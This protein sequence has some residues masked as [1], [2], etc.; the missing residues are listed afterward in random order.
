MYRVLLP[1]DTDET[2]ARAQ[3]EAVLEL[4][5]AAD[6]VVVDVV[7]VYED[8]TARDAE[9]AAG[10]F[11]DAFESEMAKRSVED[12][13]PPSIETIAD[14]LEDAGIEYTL[15]ETGGKPAEKILEAAEELD[16][17]VMILGVAERTPVGKVLFGSVAQAVILSSE[18]PVMTVS[19]ERV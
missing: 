1:V 16:V 3:L 18:C 19:R 7:H 13:R 2:R 4:P 12:R 9:W 15:H 11:A 10:G 17:D 8:T 14:S 6:E 5:G